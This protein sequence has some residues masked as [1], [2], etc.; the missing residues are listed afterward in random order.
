MKQILKSSSLVLIALSGLYA[1]SVKSDFDKSVTWERYHTFAWK[2]GARAAT[3]PVDNSLLRNRI[4]NAFS[5]ELTKRGF[6]PANGAADVLITYHL[7]VKQQRDVISTGG[8]G[9]GFYGRRGFGGYGG[10]STFTNRYLAENMVVDMVDAHTGE[11]I[12]RAYV[13]DTASKVP[14]L[15]STAKIDKMAQKAF[16]NFPRR[17]A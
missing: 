8:F 6:V 14:D 5:S 4:H 9:P 3:G 10:G 13:N 1:Q 11:L 7:D 12:W 15:E 2:D 16:K 17:P